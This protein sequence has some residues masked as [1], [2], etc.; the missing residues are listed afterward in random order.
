LALKGSAVA[1]SCPG[2]A[3]AG[4]AKKLMNIT[5]RQNSQLFFTDMDN[6]FVVK[7]SKCLRF[8]EILVRLEIP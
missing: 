2:A 7:R 3:K 8:P 4:T 6:L 5:S 1:I